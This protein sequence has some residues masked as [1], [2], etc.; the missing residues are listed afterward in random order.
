MNPKNVSLY[1]LD[2]LNNPV[3]LNEYLIP[4]KDADIEKDAYDSITFLADVIPLEPP[5]PRYSH[6]DATYY[7]RAYTSEASKPCVSGSSTTQDPSYYNPAY[8]WY[9]CNDCANYVSQAL[10]FGGIPMNSTWRPYTYAWIN[11]DGLKNF[12][13]NSYYWASASRSTCL[14]GDP[15]TWGSDHV[16][17]CSYNQG[18]VFKY[19]AHTSDRKDY[20]YS[21]STATYWRVIY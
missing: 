2:H 9:Q 17:M 18:G 19:C 20:I 10:Y 13:V 5:V 12:M 16:A 6:S 3:P 21:G 8:S 7:I 15:L 4:P 1:A 14:P 11:V